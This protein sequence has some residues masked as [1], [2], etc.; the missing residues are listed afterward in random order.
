MVTPHD[1]GRCQ[2]SRQM[3]P[4]PSAAAELEKKQ[5]KLDKIIADFIDS[6][7]SNE[8]LKK[9]MK[10]TIEKLQTEIDELE[11][12]YRIALKS[13]STLDVLNGSRSRLKDLHSIFQNL[14]RSFHLNYT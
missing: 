2:H 4:P 13:S 12:K 11:Y 6:E 3:G 8:V 7:E 14:V 9:A 1:V 5:N 10:S